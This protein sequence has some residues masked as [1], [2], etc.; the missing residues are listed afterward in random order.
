MCCPVVGTQ[1]KLQNLDHH[2]WLRPKW[3]GSKQYSRRVSWCLAKAGLAGAHLS[4]RKEITAPSPMLGPPW[5]HPGSF[6]FCVL[7]LAT[8]QGQVSS[9]LFFLLPAFMF[10]KPWPCSRHFHGTYRWPP[11]TQTSVKGFS[12]V[13]TGP[14]PCTVIHLRTGTWASS[15]YCPASPT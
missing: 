15:L 5:T 2:T 13:Q 3:P 1:N 7:R 11:R 14:F 12:A 8:T 6:L 9:W 10:L 4:P